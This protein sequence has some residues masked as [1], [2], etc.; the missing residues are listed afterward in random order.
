M[1][2]DT[3]SKTAGSWHVLGELRERRVARHQSV[4]FHRLQHAFAYR[5]DLV[6]EPL[7]NDDSE[8]LIK[9]PLQ[10][11]GCPVL[12][13]K[14]VAGRHAQ[15]EDHSPEPLSSRT[16]RVHSPT[17]KGYRQW[18]RSPVVVRVLHELR[19]VCQCPRASCRHTHVRGRCGARKCEVY[20]SCLG[21]EWVVA[22][23]GN[24]GP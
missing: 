1:R 21:H 6:G 19:L 2:C 3:E 23:Y 15:M 18:C 5:L 14:L 7:Y 22:K 24:I 12:A 8:L 4:T 16:E 10:R 20:G 13:R 9:E 17:I 11:W